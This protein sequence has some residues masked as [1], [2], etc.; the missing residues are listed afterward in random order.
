[1]AGVARRRLEPGSAVER[2]A[3]RLLGLASVHRGRRE[4][5][6][7]GIWERGGEDGSRFEGCDVVWAVVTSKYYAPLAAAKV[8]VCAEGHWVDEMVAVDGEVGRAAAV[9][10]LLS[11]LEEPAPFRPRTSPLGLALQVLPGDSPCVVEVCEDVCRMKAAVAPH[12]EAWMRILP[13][14]GG[15]V[16]H[17]PVAQAIAS[18]RAELAG[19]LQ[20]SCL[21]TRLHRGGYVPLDLEAHRHTWHR[22]IMP[23]CEGA[24]SAGS[25]TAKARTW[26]GAI[27]SAV[28]AARWRTSSGSEASA[29]A[30]DGGTGAPS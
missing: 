18:L 28:E 26:G 27:C 24:Q 22:T 20:G 1:M 29:R 14:E 16:V 12:T 9:M 23:F 4:R 7:R 30:G 25:R 3:A 17:V 11:A 15:R 19:R 6:L 8:L 13:E 10:A 21:F 2:D 5:T